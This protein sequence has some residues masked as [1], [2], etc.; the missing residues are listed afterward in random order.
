MYIRKTVRKVKGKRYEYYLLVESVTT[1]KGPR[2]KTVCTLGDL[3]PRPRE[4]WLKLACKV[5]A[6]LSGQGTLFEGEGKEEVD[7]IVSKV[8]KF[9]ERKEG[10]KEKEAEIEEERGEEI[11]SIRPDDV[12]VEKAREGGAVHV[13]HQFWLRLGM[14]NIFREAG[15][16]E[17]AT[18]LTEVMVMNR[19]IFPSSENKMPSWI[20]RTALSD[21]LRVK[22]DEL[23]EDRLYR[24]LDKIYDVKG[25]VESKLA[26]KEKTL[27]NLDDTV[28][29]YDLTS[30]YFEG[31]SLSN[32][33]A[34]RGYSR[35][36]RPDCKQVVVGL[37]INKDG[38]PKAHEVFDGNRTDTTTLDDML[39][40]LEKRVGKREGRT[41]VVDRGMAYESNIKTIKARKY[42]YIVASRGKERNKWL[43][44]FEDFESFKEVVR[45]QKKAKVE[46]KKVERGDEVYILCLSEGRKEKDKAIRETQE[47]RM[48]KDLKK[49]Q[50]RIKKGQ[51]KKK[52]NIYEAIGRIKER[53]SRVNR[54]YKIEYNLTL[55]WKEDKKR[56][57]IAKKLDGGYILKTDRKDMDAEEIWR[58]YSL[59][60][61]AEKAFRDMKS[62]LSERPIFHQL[63]HRVQT[64]IFLCVLAYHLLIAIEK[65]MQNA[66]DYS[67]WETIRKT[68]STHQVVTVVLPTTSGATLR[69][70]KATK[71]EKEHR[72]IYKKLKINPEIITP[73]KTWS[74][75][76]KN[77]D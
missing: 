20:R 34:K 71:P 4:E 56:K 73:I 47:K 45:V 18:K 40:V 30:T 9:E 51:L 76:P 77:S 2:Q 57:E 70:R 21:I 55:Q 13:G 66:K 3:K 46:I 7:H 22:F 29:L 16:S 24:N 11:I 69:I 74:N 36:K 42:H 33:Q 44:E 43:D 50:L 52:E 60:T 61:R 31:N 62:P 75:N 65:T 19:L 72:Y 26:K 68:L 27:F 28:Y 8:R 12:N 67:S 5:E 1:P 49:L 58:T 37:V 39:N 38:F 6:V 35:D 53:Y 64:H 59:L 25:L 48:L 14:D 17:K 41:V 54:Y 23:N 15:F 32:E 63:K 10:L